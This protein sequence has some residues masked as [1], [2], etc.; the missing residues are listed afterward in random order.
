LDAGETPAGSGGELQGSKI[1]I[2]LHFIN[3]S[4]ISKFD[5]YVYDSNRYTKIGLEHLERRL[6]GSSNTDRISGT[7][8][9]KF[10]TIRT[11]AQK[12]VNDEITLDKNMCSSR[13]FSYGKQSVKFIWM[14]KVDIL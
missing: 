11:C 5:F 8:L 2:F 12:Y 7:D 10:N 3:H 14:T 1:F 13:T 4:F 9:R 6:T